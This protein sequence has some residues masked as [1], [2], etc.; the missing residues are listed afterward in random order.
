MSASS[1]PRRSNQPLLIGSLIVLVFVMLAAFGPNLAPRDPLERTLIAEIGGRT[2]GAPFPPFQSWEFPLGSDRFGRDLFSRLLYAVRPTLLLAAL[3]ALTRLAIGLL[4]GA[5]AGWPQR[6]ARFLNGLIDAALATPVL[7]TALAAITLVGIERGLPAF[8]LGLTLT[9]W[10]ETAQSV[11]AQ[12]RQIAVQPYISAAHALGANTPQILLRHLSRHLAPLIGPLFAFEI[13][14]VL[15]LTAGL[16]FLGYFIGGG[17]WVITS[18][19]LIPVAERVAGLPE[20]GQMVGTADIRLS[21]RPP[22]EILFPGTIIVCAILGFSLLGEGLRRRVQERPLN[23]GLVVRLLA[24]PFTRLEEAL[25]TR[26]GAWNPRVT[27]SI[28]LLF[29]LVFLSGAGWIWW[30]NRTVT[31]APTGLAGVAVETPGWLAQRGDPYGSLGGDSLPTTAPTPAWSFAEAVDLSTPV[32][33]PAGTIYTISAAGILYALERD[34]SL[35]W[36]LQLDSLPIGAP[37]LGPDGTIYVTE[38]RGA[39]I[40]VDPAGSERWRFQTSYRAQATS[41]PIVAPDG[42]IYYAVIDAIQAVNPDGS[43]RWL[44]RN[45]DLPFQDLLPRLSPDGTLVYLKNTVF[46]TSDGAQLLISIVPDEPVFAE[47]AFIVGADGRNYYRSEHRIIPWRRVDAGASL[48]PALSWGASN[49]FFMPA[50]VGI[51]AGGVAWMLYSTDFADTRL[52]W[53]DAE[54]TQVGEILY[55]WRSARVLAT[56]ADGSLLVC[57]RPR[58]RLPSCGVFA[59][60]SDQPLW[61]LIV[62]AAGNEVRGAG[63][64]GNR[65]YLSSNGA[66]L[67]AFD[68]Q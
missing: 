35:R 15:L 34:G 11:R 30:Q 56:Y 6:S 63:Q 43:G 8:L 65:L 17:V 28:Y 59:P 20:L 22:W 37:G 36:Q 18:G 42:I 49:A 10:A 46:R 44:G 68:L 41:G 38:S 48:Q 24:N 23:A 51:T 57:G 62:G 50:D 61:E 9:G 53:I 2:L 5:I 29:A 27:G 31:P 26:A 33:D 12:T 1:P 45:P 39:L 66:G 3:A 13:S 47:G 19:E 7:L 32:V 14:A 60:Q 54:G 64:D 40:A 25:V 4:L 16:A 55:P 58:N 21:S 67:L 52:I